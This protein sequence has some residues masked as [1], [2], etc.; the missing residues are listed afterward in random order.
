ME[1]PLETAQLSGCCSRARAVLSSIFP[2]S[3]SQL[4]Q[5]SSTFCEVFPFSPLLATVRWNPSRDPVNRAIWGKNRTLL[6]GF[7][8]VN[9]LK[10]YI[11]QE[12]LHA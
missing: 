11:T 6:P 2:E 8:N 1:T 12:T 5:Q 3:L 4:P 9:V 7:E 10:S